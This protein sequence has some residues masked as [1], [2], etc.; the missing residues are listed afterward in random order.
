MK[1]YS[2]RVIAAMFAVPEGALEGARRAGLLKRLHRLLWQR[3]IDVAYEAIVKSIL[4]VTI[5]IRDQFTP[6]I[7]RVQFSFQRFQVEWLLAEPWYRHLRTRWALR[8]A[9]EWAKRYPPIA[10]GESADAIEAVGRLG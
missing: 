5:A 9:P 6:T 3:R 4:E 8:R 2:E 10:S 1:G 7:E